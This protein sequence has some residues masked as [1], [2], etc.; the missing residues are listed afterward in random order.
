MSDK[1]RVR[2]LLGLPPA[3]A[4]LLVRQALAWVGADPDAKGPIP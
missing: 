3:T 2:A 4:P 1:S